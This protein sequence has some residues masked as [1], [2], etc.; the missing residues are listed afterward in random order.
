MKNSKISKMSALSLAVLSA[1]SMSVY[2]ADVSQ[3]GDT[4]VKTK[5]VVVTATKTEAEVKAVPQAVE[6][7]DS[8]DIQRMGANDV[9]TA[10]SLANNL[11]LSKAGMTGNAV[12]LRGMS[13]NH[14]LI[15]IDGRRQAA[16]DTDVS[17]LT[18]MRW[19]V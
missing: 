13:T 6:V 18:Y 4:Q 3:G 7:I 9:L 17:R 2:A 5:D 10:L 11:N 15:L 19:N 16:E 8:E 14:T 12:S 1:L